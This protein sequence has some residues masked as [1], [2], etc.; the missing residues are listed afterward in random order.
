MLYVIK[1]MRSLDFK[2]GLTVQK[3]CPREQNVSNVTKNGR[4]RHCI[5]FNLQQPQSR[6]S[7]FVLD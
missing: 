2:A 3:V 5:I 6:F 4:Q 1:P 7:Y